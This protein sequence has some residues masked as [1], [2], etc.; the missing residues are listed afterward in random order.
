MGKTINIK[1][2]FN[3]FGVTNIPR[4]VSQL[5]KSFSIRAEKTP[6]NGITRYKVACNWV[7][8]RLKAKPE[9]VDGIKKMVLY[10]LKKEGTPVT[11]EQAR[12]QEQL[13]QY[14]LL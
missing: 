6:R 12:E 1:T 2:G 10:V 3:L 9:N 8:Y 5:Q 7:D 13:K 4:E 11:Q 14:L